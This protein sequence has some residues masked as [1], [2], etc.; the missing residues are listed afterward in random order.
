M[1]NKLDE[2]DINDLIRKQVVEA[3]DERLGSDYRREGGSLYFSRLSEQEYVD[4][5]VAK[6]KEK[7]EE[8][9]DTKSLLLRIIEESEALVFI[10]RDG[11]QEIEGIVYDFQE[12]RKHIS[13]KGYVFKQEIGKLGELW[14]APKKEKKEDK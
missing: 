13:S 2:N 1:R 9:S 8:Y 7:N 5:L 6:Q 3:L 14:K 12:A 11:F 10:V 4:S